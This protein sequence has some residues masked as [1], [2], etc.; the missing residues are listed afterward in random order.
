MLQIT[1]D[2]IT[3]S[4]QQYGPMFLGGCRP[5]GPINKIEVRMTNVAARRV[6][7]LGRSVRIEPPHFLAATSIY[8][9][10]YI[11]CRAEPVGAIFRV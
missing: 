11:I 2:S 1:H 10:L 9:N 7:G 4:L 3:T 8:Q 6:T 5:P